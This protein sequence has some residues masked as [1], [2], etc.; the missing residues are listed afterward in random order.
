MQWM[1]M[2]SPVSA[3]PGMA[4][5]VQLDEL[6]DAEGADADRLFLTLMREHHRGG[7]HMSLNAAANASDGD[8]RSL[9]RRMATYQQVEVNEY[10][11]LMRYLGFEQ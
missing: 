1:D 11:I 5:E 10:T 8:V 6:R 3:M 9:A 7:A 4:S 2:G